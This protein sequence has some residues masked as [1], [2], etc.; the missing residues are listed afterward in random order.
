MARIDYSDT[1]K[2]SDRTREIL[3][4]N[5][6]ANIFRILDRLSRSLDDRRNLKHES[7]VNSINDI[8]QAR[9]SASDL[10]IGSV[11]EALGMSDAYICRIYKQ[12]TSHTILDTIVRMRMQKARELLKNS[13]DPVTLIAEKCGFA[14]STYFYTAFKAANGV[15]PSDYRKNHQAEG[16]Q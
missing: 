11:A 16:N 12:Y 8:I 7:I 4:K 1:S 13:G 2:A 3:D 15:T 6:N 5:R 10:S 9:Y 14:N